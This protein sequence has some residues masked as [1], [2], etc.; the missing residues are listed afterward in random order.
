MSEDKVWHELGLL[1]C[2]HGWEGPDG[3][4]IP[5]PKCM[6]AEIQRLRQILNPF[7]DLDGVLVETLELLGDTEEGRALLDE[8]AR[9]REVEYGAMCE[10]REAAV[11]WHR[12]R[13]AN[14]A[15][16]KNFAES[17]GQIS[18]ATVTHERL[19]AAAR[20]VAELEET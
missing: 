16:F 5:C 14:E 10:L 17:Q 8:D 9:L 12:T 15:P 19:T 4:P 7:S 3:E 13:V 20:A 11:L 6:A 1:G 2:T 18:M